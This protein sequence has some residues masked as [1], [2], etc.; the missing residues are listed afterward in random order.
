[1]A[2]IAKLSQDQ[3]VTGLKLSGFLPGWL[4]P[5]ASVTVTSDADGNFVV[6]SDQEAPDGDA[7]DG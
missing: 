2:Q 7:S 4:D 3:L 6:E 1:M 5:A